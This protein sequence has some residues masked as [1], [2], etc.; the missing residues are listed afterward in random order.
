M[1]HRASQ[2]MKGSIGDQRASARTPLHLSGNVKRTEAAADPHVAFSR[3]VSTTGLFF[4]SNLPAEVG[5]DLT[6]TF[7]TPNGGCLMFQGR[8]VRIEHRSAGAARG[9]ALVLSSRVLAA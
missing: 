5:E 4:F 1:S 3:D 7:V 8:V 2:Y 6:L 9:I